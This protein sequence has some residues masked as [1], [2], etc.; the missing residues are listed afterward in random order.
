MTQYDGSIRVGTK[1]ETKEAERELK[2]L[3]SSIQKTAD[4]I[5]SLCSKMDALKDVKL[6]T[7]EYQEISAQIEKAEQR[8]NKLL[9]KQEW[10]QRGGKDSGATWERLNYQ[11]DEVGNEIRYAQGELQELVD[12]GKAFTLGANTDEYAQ[13]SVQMEQLTSKMQADQKRIVGIQATLASEEQRLVNIK[14]NAIRSDEE[15]I[16]LLERKKQ[17]TQEI[18]D[19]ERSGLGY[20]YQEYDSKVQ[21]LASID[22]QIKNYKAHLNDM[23][24]SYIRMKDAVKMAFSAIAK[25][26]VDIP[27]ATVKSGIN[28]LASSFSKMGSIIKGS[29]I[30]SFKFLGSAAKR[31]F[32]AISS[33]SKKS[34]GLLSTLSSRIKGL[35]F[36]LLIFNWISKAFNS[37][38]SG[39]KQGFSNF[40]NYSSGFANSVQSMKNAMSTLGNQIAAAF[41]PIIQ[42]V[43]PWITKLINAISTAM[44][45]VAQFI[46]LL[47][48]K[49][50]FT[51]AKKVQDSYNS[52]LGG[53]ASKSKKAADATDS[54]A[55]SLDDAASSAKKAR[56]ALAQFDDL[57]VLEKQDDNVEDKIK[58]MNDSLDDLGSGIGVAGDLFEEVPIS[59]QIKDFLD[60]LKEMWENSDFYEL[61]K[62]LGEKLKEALDNIPWDE[63]KEIARKI[64]KSIA[65]F[66]NGFI[67]VEGLGESIGR[68][69]AEVINT[70]FEFLNAFVHE[71]HWDS[72][73]KFIAETINGFFTS[74]DWD[75]IYDTFITGAKGLSDALNAFADHLDW[76]AIANAVSNFINTFIDTIYAFVTNTDWIALAES[77]GKSI[78]D[79]VA[80]V[81]WRK[82]GETLGEVFKA[83]FDFIATTI[84]NIDWWLVGE[85]VKEFLVGIDWAGVAEAFFEAIGAA[86]GGLAAFLGG[87]IA[88]GVENAKAY[89]EDKIEE[90][91]G[92]VVE[93]ILV[94]IAEAL[95]DIGNWIYEHIFIPFIEGFQTA[96]GIHS[97]STVMQ[98]MGVFI[99]QGLLNGIISLVESVT[100]IWES[101][102]QTAI[103]AWTLVQETLLTIWETIVETA[104][105]I[106]ES[107]E[108]FFIDTW[109]NIKL[110][111]ETVWESITTTLQTTWETIEATAM[112][113][114]ETIK[115]FL[116]ET[117][118]N[119]SKK[120]DTVW[121]TIKE[122]IET[123]IQ[124]VSETIT[125]T[126]ETVKTTWSDAWESL[127]ETVNSIIES[128]KE[129]IQAAF[130][131]ISDMVSSI[132]EKL[133]SIGSSIA[134]ALRFGGSTYSVSVEG[135][136]P[137]PINMI[138]NIPHL[139]SGSVIRGGN[140]FLAMLGDQP[141]GQTNI[142]APLSTIEQAV[143]NAM[144][145]RGNSGG[146]PVNINLNWDG[147]TFARISIPDFLAELA[148]QGYDVEVLGVS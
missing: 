74:I 61:G 95:V 20:G 118:D 83:F 11:I 75:L 107:I 111:V 84:E 9:E 146:V 87:L 19:M 40:I 103:E 76:G 73:G 35:V 128:I 38:I 63:I 78:T 104:I 56:G 55:D 108:Q 145:R 117:W 57:D 71:L 64:G 23:Q 14:A 49:S 44:T 129:T 98:E 123:T 18:T 91:G 131:W 51:R 53:T 120:V 68:T 132:G 10:M 37:M 133:G 109:E 124:N 99:I 136:N 41:A 4:K 122:R 16:G 130:D 101:M 97:P 105:T 148:R 72:I 30:S 121:T 13:M 115:T 119:I 15:M 127:K 134:G 89:F 43:L 32:N 69:L 34:S 94:G 31:A 110:V 45:Y 65:S 116:A 114:F 66:I 27:I 67:E 2:D 90:A 33:G 113:I 77:I 81:D 102:K 92:N 86:I 12:T 125:S 139:A 1:I 79:A 144:N 7:K 25:G 39:M 138:D 135:S 50:T 62:L 52:S 82:A 8:F 6:P 59:D 36:S 85:S 137:I 22:Q 17:L 147:E 100:A 47:G 28:S 143:E 112:L 3:E 58:D 140:P 26:L 24:S 88:E 42:M 70:G 48:G 80:S 54:I 106:W 60:W 29:A 46:A 93:G 141:H 96:F 21:E 142:E 5:T 126:M